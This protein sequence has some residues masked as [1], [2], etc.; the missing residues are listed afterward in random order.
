MW[1]FAA[2][3]ASRKSPSFITCRASRATGTARPWRSA[4]SRRSWR[5]GFFDPLQ[6]KLLL[7]DGPRGGKVIIFQVKE[8][9]IIRD[10]QYRGLKSATES[11]VLTRF[12]ERRTQVSKE[13]QLRPSQGQCGQDRACAN[14]SPRKGHPQGRSHHRGRGHFRHHRGPDLQCGRRRRACA[15]RRSSFTGDRGDFSQRRLRGAMKLVKEAGIIS[16]FKSADIYFKEKL[17]DDLERVRFL[18][19]SERLSAGQVRRAANRRRGPGQRRHYH[20]RSCANPG[21]ACA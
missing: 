13:N 19:G 4:I 11:D 18:P 16:T 9:P 14:C 5:L 3:A 17:Q 8:Y 15:S 7:D 20:C 6:T 1:K 2:I 12:K 21:R 10:L